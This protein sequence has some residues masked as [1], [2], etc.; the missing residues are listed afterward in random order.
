M[1]LCTL[2]PLGGNWTLV[3]ESFKNVMNQTREARMS[4][5][6]A[7]TLI[8]FIVSISLAQTNSG[9]KPQPNASS[10]YWPIEKSQPIIDK[11]QTITLAPDLSQLT[12][13]ERI[14]VDKLLE[15]G[16]IFQKL[17]EE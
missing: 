13:A 3:K 15:V 7:I 1:M 10:G 4:K 12:A 6:V 8:L 17:Y 11:T 5:L 14:A 9:M 2:H 16:Q